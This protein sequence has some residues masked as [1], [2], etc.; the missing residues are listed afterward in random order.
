MDWLIRF[1]DLHGDIP[2]RIIALS[3]EDKATLE[4]AL[5]RSIMNGDE[6]DLGRSPD[7][8]RL[9]DPLYFKPDYTGDANDHNI[10][11][12]PIY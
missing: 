5:G 2:D 4:A 3:R 9:F 7:T 12:I 6:I 8:H 10:I 11:R 1:T